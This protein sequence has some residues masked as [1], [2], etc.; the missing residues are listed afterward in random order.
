MLGRH[1][2]A[3]ADGADPDTPL[4]AAHAFRPPADMTPA[5]GLGLV[6]AMALVALSGFVSGRLLD[7]LGVRALA[8]VLL[9]L[10]AAASRGLSGLRTGGHA[11]ISAGERRV[12]LGLLVLAVLTGSAT[13]LALLPAVVHAAVARLLVASLDDD[14]TLIEK[15]AR[16][17]HPLAPLFI[18]PYCRKLT[19]VWAAAFAVS[20]GMIAVFA[21]SGAEELHRAWT[22]W[23]FWT[24]LGAF[25]GVE[26]LWRKA[27]FRYFGRG[28]LDRL[29]ARAFP[30]QST[31]RGRRSEA[32][33]RSMRAELARLAEAERR[34]RTSPG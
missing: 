26:F 9:A 25:S 22:G 15:G 29:L 27:W 33:L 3:I 24:V 5:Q 21:L 32:Y 23:V 20:A 28:P 1:A 11:S 17:S 4:T 18:G 34:R 19:V 31:E 8:L 7:A 16:L 2:R 13:A 12:L 10:A 30:P 6:A 14:L